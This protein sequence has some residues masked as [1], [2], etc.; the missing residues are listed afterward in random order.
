VKHSREIGLDADPELQ[1]FLPGQRP[2]LEAQL[3]DL[4]DEIAYNTADI[5]DSFSLGLFSLDDLA[6]AVP[7]FGEIGEQ[8]ETQ[9][10]GAPP[11]V[12]FWEIQRQLLCVLMGGLIEG[13]VAAADASGVQTVEDVR[14]LDY[15]LARFTPIVAQINAQM[16]ALLVSHVYSSMP[17]AEDRRIAVGKIAELFHYLIDHPDKVSPG[18][19]QY[20]D[21]MPVHRVVCDYIAG[22]TDNYLLRTYDTLLGS[23]AAKEASR[24]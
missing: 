12:R 19:H 3:L 9:F 16:K 22:M 20:L 14:V 23:G 24:T 6:A 18:Y 21:E 17:L 11:R 7:V 2:P 15:R 4:A 10:P 5:D 1:E 8:I 13:T